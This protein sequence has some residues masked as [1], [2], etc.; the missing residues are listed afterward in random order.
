[1]RNGFEA[2][3]S[4]RSITGHKQVGTGVAKDVLRIITRWLNPFKVKCALV[5]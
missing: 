4:I 3:F 5:A 1:L 2:A